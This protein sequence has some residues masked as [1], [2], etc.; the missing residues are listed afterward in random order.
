MPTSDTVPSGGQA[1]KNFTFVGM[2]D[3]LSQRLYTQLGP[4]EA[5]HHDIITPEDF[6]TQEESVDHVVVL[7][8]QD[9]LSWLQ[10]RMGTGIP[11]G[12]ALQQWVARAEVFLGTLRAHRPS[13]FVVNLD[14]VL[15]H[16]E[17]LRSALTE[18]YNCVFRN[19]APGP[20]D[21]RNSKDT[22]HEYLALNTFL[23][24]AYARRL[25]S[26][27]DASASID[28][29]RGLPKVVDSNDVFQNFIL[30]EKT[31]ADLQNDIRLQKDLVDF[32]ERMLR[33]ASIRAEQA[34]V[35]I[36]RLQAEL[37]SANRNFETRLA[38]VHSKIS[39]F[40]EEALH[41]RRI[42]ENLQKQLDWTQSQL[43]DV[44][45]SADQEAQE[46]TVLAE[47]INGFRED[48]G[49]LHN[50]VAARDAHIEAIR[51]STSWRLTGPLRRFRRLFWKK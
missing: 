44:L 22:V 33:A 26:E 43:R 35:E 37:R 25:Q 8:Y 15:T 39:A 46:K 49:R 32:K 16:P 42:A 14:L 13:V 23:K 19:D 12:E 20:I 36:N 4:L 47:R 5:A 29:V 51:L 11:P 30:T 2:T 48:I 38:G 31:N 28:V 6:S 24:S 40:E 3:A 50:E 34:N 21:N 9:C 17:M 41:A 45:V 18:A 10:E 1:S 27:L 7:V